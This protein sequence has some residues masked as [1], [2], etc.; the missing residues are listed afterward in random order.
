M[1]QEERFMRISI[2]RRFSLATLLEVTRPMKDLREDEIER[3]FRDINR[4]LE[5]CRSE[6]DFYRQMPD[7]T[8]VSQG[9]SGKIAA[10]S[11]TL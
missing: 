6:Q 3:R 2:K 1:T 8:D 11:R 9:D 5:H 10:I 4:L 7:F